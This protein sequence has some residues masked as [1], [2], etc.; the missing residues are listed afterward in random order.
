MYN[1]ADTYHKPQIAMYQF[2]VQQ[3]FSTAKSQLK[4][5]KDKIIIFTN[6]PEDIFQ[7]RK[8]SLHNIF[9]ILNRR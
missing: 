5:N 8:I 4:K 1:V 6:F 7:Q 9:Y 3:Y 2:L